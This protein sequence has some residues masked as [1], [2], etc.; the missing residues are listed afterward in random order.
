M[1][2]KYSK[3]CFTEGAVL[4]LR[5]LSKEKWCTSQQGYTDIGFTK[6]TVTQIWWKMKLCIVYWGNSN[7]G[8]IEGEVMQISI[9]QL[10]IF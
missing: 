1:S 2:I 6:G 10:Y 3:A 7:L 9:E 8:L 5:F 4:L